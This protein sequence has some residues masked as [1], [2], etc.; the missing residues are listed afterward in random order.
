MRNE[1]FSEDIRKCQNVFLFAFLIVHVISGVTT[2]SSQD[3][4][5]S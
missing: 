2:A 1:T 3:G 5:L 4:K